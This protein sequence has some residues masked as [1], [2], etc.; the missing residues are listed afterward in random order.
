[1]PFV[2]K[3]IEW[4]TQTV[5]S[6]CGYANKQMY[7]ILKYSEFVNG[8]LQFDTI[9]TYIFDFDTG[10]YATNLYPVTITNNTGM[11]TN[12]PDLNIPRQILYGRLGE[13]NERWLV[14]CGGYRANHCELLDTKSTTPKW[15]LMLSN[16]DVCT[17]GSALVG[18][19][20]DTVI[21]SGGI[22][23]L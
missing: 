8:T 22:C 3:T 16:T 1:M 12:G 15:K 14:V 19:G 17:Y 6:T 21:I 7:C 5:W 4:E 11:W 2:K 23:G 18:Y 20:V 10:K 13:V 9:N